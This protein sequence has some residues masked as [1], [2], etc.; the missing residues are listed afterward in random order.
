MADY[1]QY[2]PSGAILNPH[3]YPHGR[4][5]LSGLTLMQAA[6]ERAARTSVLNWIVRNVSNE[7]GVAQADIRGKCRRADIVAARHEAMRRASVAGL[8]T[9]WIAKAFSVKDKAVA[10][11]LAR[12]DVRHG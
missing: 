10:Y 3:N 7:S 8:P 4:P 2:T 5:R 6:K 11:A 12:G 1:S 9:Y